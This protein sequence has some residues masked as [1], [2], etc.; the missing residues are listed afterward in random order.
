MS[1][2]SGLK[3]P[4]DDRQ[5]GNVFKSKEGKFRV[6][7]REKFTTR[8]MMKHCNRLCREAVDAHLWQHSR[9]GGWGPEQPDLENDIPV[10]GRTAG[11]R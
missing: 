10:R 9:P 5:R 2:H 7:I 1:V 11:I 6:H 3:T 8:R 4:N